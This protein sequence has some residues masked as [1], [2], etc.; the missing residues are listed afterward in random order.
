MSVRSPF[1]SPFDK[2][3]EVDRLKKAFTPYQSD[4]LTL[5]AA[6]K[7]WQKSKELKQVKNKQIHQCEIVSLHLC[8]CLFVCLFVC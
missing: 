1:L 7:G 3:D 4:H 5:L 8:I 6:Y 2:R